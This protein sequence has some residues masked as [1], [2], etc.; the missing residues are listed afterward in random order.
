MKNPSI[1]SS[2]LFGAIRRNS[3]VYIGEERTQK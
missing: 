2:K 3:L 1:N